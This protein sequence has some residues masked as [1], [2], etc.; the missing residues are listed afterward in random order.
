MSAHHWKINKESILTQNKK[1]TL[2]SVSICWQFDRYAA[3]MEHISCAM[4]ISVNRVIDWNR[5]WHTKLRILVSV[6]MLIELNR[7]ELNFH[8]EWNTFFEVKIFENRFENSILIPFIDYMVLCI[9][10]N[11]TLH[12]IWWYIGGLRMETIKYWRIIIR[13]KTGKAAK[14]Q[15]KHAS[16]P[17]INGISLGLIVIKF[18]ALFIYYNTSCGERA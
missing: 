1:K 2:F 3:Y 18:Y 7:T 4:L 14:R 11:I 17:S 13:L 12:H 8:C 10:E 5:Q 9:F 15:L 16:Y 6:L